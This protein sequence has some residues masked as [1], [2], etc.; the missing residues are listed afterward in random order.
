METEALWCEKCQRGIGGIPG[1]YKDGD[2]CP[3][4]YEKEVMKGNAGR[5]NNVPQLIT[6]TQAKKNIERYA[7]LKSLEK[8]KIRG[9]ETVQELR[10][11]IE[12]KFTSQISDQQ[13]L[14]DKLTQQVEKLT[15]TQQVEKLTKTNK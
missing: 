4:C 14:I 2:D 7:E 13:A 11:S 3:I 1:N 12:N 10:K 8:K 6:V 15:N 9:Q 5:M